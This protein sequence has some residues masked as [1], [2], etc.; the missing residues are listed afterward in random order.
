MIHSLYNGV[1][2]D[3]YHQRYVTYLNKEGGSLASWVRKE[4]LASGVLEL[5][6]RA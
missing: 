4:L 3:L 2:Q 6:F 5:G 1:M